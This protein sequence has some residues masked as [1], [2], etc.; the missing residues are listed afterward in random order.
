MRSSS[1]RVDSIL[2]AAMALTLWVGVS[3]P[4]PASQIVAHPAGRVS[5]PLVSVAKDAPDQPALRV[6]DDLGT[7]LDFYLPPGTTRAVIQP[8]SDGL[9][10]GFGWVSAYDAQGNE[11]LRQRETI[12]IAFQ[13]GERGLLVGLL[14]EHADAPVELRVPAGTA[15]VRLVSQNFDS[16]SD[17]RKDGKVLAFDAQGA[18]LAED[19]GLALDVLTP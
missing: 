9:D 1:R 5:A 13:L 8:G 7:R 6:V 11:L 3:A 2:A 10:G 16:A 14:G 15:R 18:V 19:N 12:G 17:P 4:V